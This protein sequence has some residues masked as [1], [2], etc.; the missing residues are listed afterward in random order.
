[1]K[2]LSSERGSAIVWILIA[3]FLFAALS[4]VMMQ[5]NRSSTSM[6]SDEEAKAYA[7]QIISFGN[8]MKTTVKRL[9]LRGCEDNEIN[10]SNS[11]YKFTASPSLDA[12]VQNHNPNSP[13]NESCNIFSANGGQITP[14][15]FTKGAVT[16]ASAGGLFAGDSAVIVGRVNGVGTTAPELLLFVIGID[17]NV[18]EHINKLLGINTTDPIP[19]DGYSAWTPFSAANVNYDAAF[20]IFGDDDTQL[21][22]K[23]A[24]CSQ[25][26]DAS[27]A[28]MYFQV[29][30]SR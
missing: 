7:T 14:K 21:T 30:I 16:S 17:L 26:N 5:G 22:G 29:L 19:N 13:T 15:Q 4:Y 12:W 11:I 1:M 25:V 23:S 27:T 10:F 28:G 2:T 6:L 18:C 9:Q 20:S 3:V 8:E 24:F